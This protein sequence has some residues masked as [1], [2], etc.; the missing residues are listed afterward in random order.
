MS[1][2]IYIYMYFNSH[3]F[4]NSQCALCFH[5]ILLFPVWVLVKALLLGDATL[6]NHPKP[7]RIIFL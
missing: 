4:I 2:Y 3:V 5:R 7:V 6:F 1:I